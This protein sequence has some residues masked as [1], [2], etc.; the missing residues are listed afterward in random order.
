MAYAVKTDAAAFAM[1]TL[2][3]NLFTDRENPLKAVRCTRAKLRL[4]RGRTGRYGMTVLCDDEFNLVCYL[5]ESGSGMARHVADFTEAAVLSHATGSMDISSKSTSKSGEEALGIDAPTIERIQDLDTL[6]IEELLV[7][8][9]VVFVTGESGTGKSTLAC[10]LQEWWKRTAFARDVEYFDALPDIDR[11]L[12]G[13]HKPKSL[14]SSSA[15]KLG[16]HTTKPLM[17]GGIHDYDQIILFD[18]VESWDT[19]L[20]EDIKKEEP[21]RMSNLIEHCQQ[22]P[23]KRRMIFFTRIT[24]EVLSS[25][26]PSTVI[27]EVC[28]P[29]VEEATTIAAHYLSEQMPLSQAGAADL[30]D[31]I[32]HHR[33][34]LAFLHIFI[35]HMAQ[36]K[37]QPKDLIA[38]LV[39]EPGACNFGNF[40][41][42]IE[43][44]G[45]GAAVFKLVHDHVQAWS[46]EHWLS[47][48][49][50]FPF[51]MF[52]CRI[53]QDVK[54]WFHKLYEKGLFT[55]GRPMAEPFPMESGKIHFYDIEGWETFPPD[56]HFEQNWMR[57]RDCL[58]TGGL[59]QKERAM[60]GAT[61]QY[62]RAH[63]LLPYFLRYEITQLPL[64]DP[65]RYWSLLSLAYWEY[66]EVRANSLTLSWLG[67]PSD[68]YS[69]LMN[70]NSD[71]INLA[72]AVRL[73]VEQPC[74]AFRIMRVYNLIPHL[75]YTSMRQGQ[76]RQWAFL[77]DQ[78][79]ARFERIYLEKEWSDKPSQDLRQSLLL[80]SM[81]I[82]E[83]RG[84]VFEK[85]GRS[86][87]VI[88]NTERAIRLK[89]KFTQDLRVPTN[90][91]IEATFYITQAQRAKA[92][93]S[94]HWSSADLELFEKL[95]ITRLPDGLLPNGARMKVARAELANRL[96][97]EKKNLPESHPLHAMIEESFQEGIVFIQS[98]FREESALSQ[99]LPL[100]ART[101]IT[102]PAG[103]ESIDPKSVLDGYISGQNIIHAYRSIQE[104]FLKRVPSNDPGYSGDARAYTVDTD[105]LLRQDKFVFH[106]SRLRRVYEIALQ[107]KDSGNQAFCLEHLSTAAIIDGD[108]GAADQY[109][110][111]WKRLGLDLVNDG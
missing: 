102:Y 30:E 29:T 24:E 37:I 57:V 69:I 35:R 7:G 83:R 91:A 23:G 65:Q 47:F 109:F 52:H 5:A 94:D 105:A 95:L 56:W 111:A 6:S 31:L 46:Q 15:E 87:A 26:F 58:E 33:M 89:K 21:S 80:Y 86:K 19:L 77:L 96:A 54:V 41:Q 13:S 16:N 99:H 67:K 48:R 39:R 101:A 70:I 18:N 4:K 93:P 10:H 59:I 72:E 40:K 63:P 36:L 45:S 51:C 34:N 107:Q 90:D 9:D 11:W 20:R 82:A 22:S 78:V 1:R 43:A 62:F 98:I 32:K 88:D 42:Y 74:F 61:E 44:K 3:S 110:K 53:P 50:F 17:E 64:K 49:M 79:L 85:L 60:P 12:E 92:I 108:L 66:H 103:Q 106:R 84:L 75:N 25:R 73:T 104:D 100:G 97:D 8:N 14:L 28:I 27:H 76:L 71:V 81:Q 2:Y 55:G 68:R 38:H